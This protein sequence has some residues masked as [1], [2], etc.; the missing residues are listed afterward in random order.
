MS[1][2]RLSAGNK[3]PP[4]SLS[5]LQTTNINRLQRWMA[6]VRL[7]GIGNNADFRGL[8]SSFAGSCPYPTIIENKAD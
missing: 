7:C 6:A 4:D 8:P 2:S 3:A 5:I 1:W